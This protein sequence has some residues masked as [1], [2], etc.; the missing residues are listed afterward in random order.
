MLMNQY[1]HIG[2]SGLIKRFFIFICIEYIIFFI[3]C[4]PTYVGKQFINYPRNLF[5]ELWRCL[6]YFFYRNRYVIGFTDKFANNIP[7]QAMLLQV[8]INFANM[9]FGFSQY[10]KKWWYY[11]ILLISIIISV[12]LIDCYYIL[13]HQDDSI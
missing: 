11:L 4:L 13:I 8:I 12:C 6:G 7:S 1:I 9:I 5:P 2:K 3:I 10:K